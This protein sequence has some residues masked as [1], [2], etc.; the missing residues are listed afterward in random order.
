[1]QATISALELRFLDDAFELV[2]EEFEGIM[3]DASCEFVLTTG[4]QEQVE[5]ARLL[6]T[7]LLKRLTAGET[8]ESTD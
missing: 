4:A 1:M 6:L 3:E 5:E 7:E 2:E 8:D